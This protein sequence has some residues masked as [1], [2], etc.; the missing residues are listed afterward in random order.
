MTPIRTLLFT[1]LL[2]IGS[3]TLCSG[4]SIELL[5]LPLKVHLIEGADMVR[6]AGKS[7]AEAKRTEMNMPVSV[8]DAAKVMKQVNE[9]WAPSGIEWVTQPD[10]GGGGIITEQAGGG[11][12]SADQAKALAQL[13]VARNR[14]GKLRYME[15]V[16][17]ALTDPANNENINA[18]GTRN[19]EA[20]KMY[21]LYLF[22][23]IG[24][25]LQGTASISGT[26]AVVGVFSD[27][28]PN[29][30][31]FPRLRPYVIPDKSQP[32]LS[33]KN[34][35]R[36]G[37]LSATI[38]HELGHNL[39]LLHVDE[40]MKDN[41]MKGHVKL[42]LGPAQMKKAR[43]QAMKGPRLPTVESLD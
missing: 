35:P 8:E 42:R 27:K 18:D 41:L 22:P 21:H 38:A 7:G 12:L 39:S 33:P 14:G 20:P 29:K 19:R 25:T 31:G 1:F 32:V 16:F 13:V 40:G 10:S 9:I 36:D 28:R 4:D 3:G 23:Y 26:F 2:L 43:V 5:R 17:P 37:A 24:Q 34:F 30:E 6:E 11:H 15:W